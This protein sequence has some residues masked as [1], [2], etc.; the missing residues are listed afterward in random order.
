MQRHKIVPWIAVTVFLALTAQLSWGQTPAEAYDRLAYRLVEHASDG[1]HGIPAGIRVPADIGSDLALEL[2]PLQ[3]GQAM[4]A[5]DD[6][7][8]YTA[9]VDTAFEITVQAF[10]DDIDGDRSVMHV[11][12]YDTL[13]LGRLQ[14][15]YHAPGSLPPVRLELDRTRWS[16]NHRVSVVMRLRRAGEEGTQLFVET[17]RV[18][19][20]QLG[21]HFRMSSSLIFSRLDRGTPEGERWRPNVM[22]QANWFHTARNPGALGGFWKWLSPGAGVHLASLDHGPDTVEF[23]IG[24]NVALWDGLISVGYGRNL[25]IDVDPE[26]R[27]IGI[28]LFDVLN[29]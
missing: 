7:L 9:P 4:P 23:G 8:L 27:F 14:D 12:G 15:I 1:I 29:Q 19:G 26:Y 2:E 16:L 11:A 20:E 10:L 3:P 17:W 22:A 28:N 25:S 24:V 6:W 21:L 13:P 5:G 18:A